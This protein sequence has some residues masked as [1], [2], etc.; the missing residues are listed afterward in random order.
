MHDSLIKFVLLTASLWGMLKLRFDVVPT[1]DSVTLQNIISVTYCYV[2]SLEPPLP[3]FLLSNVRCTSGEGIPLLTQHSLHQ[4]P[5][6]IHTGSSTHLGITC[7]HP[8][9]LMLLYSPL[10]FGACAPPLQPPL[11]RLRTE[12]CCYFSQKLIYVRMGSIL[13]M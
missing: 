9:I 3:L 1:S 5:Y 8:R 11:N 12:K 10:P 13:L 4:R 6:F 7:I 2:F